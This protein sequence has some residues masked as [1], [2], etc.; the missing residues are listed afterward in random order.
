MSTLASNIEAQPESL[1]R[2]L[3]HQ[4]GDG[5]AAMAHAATLLRSGKKVVI[6]AMGA[7]LFAS[8][9]LQYSLCSLGLD[10]VAVEAGEL[11]I[12]GQLLERRSGPDG[13]PFRR[14]G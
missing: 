14:V 4:C 13:F 3:R 7:S 10:A 11:L 1:D 5:A 12:S 9:P 8:I 2:T 6:T